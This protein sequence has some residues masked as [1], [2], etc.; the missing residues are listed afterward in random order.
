MSQ[1]T[2][3]ALGCVLVG[4]LCIGG[5]IQQ[6]RTGETWGATGKGRVYRDQEPGYFWGMFV[7]RVVLG[8][9]AAIGGLVALSHA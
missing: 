4:L 1:T 5:A 3:I 9:I 7:A 8:P 2:A 6:V